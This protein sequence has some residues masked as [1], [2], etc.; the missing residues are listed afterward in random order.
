MAK[1]KRLTPAQPD[2]L[3]PAPDGLRPLGGMTP[4][5]IAQV[6]GEASARAALSEL[7]TAM[8]AARDEGRLIETLPLGAIDPAYLMRDRVVQDEDEMDALMTSIRVRGQQTP[9]EV[10]RLSDPKGDMAYGLISGWRRLTA[11]QR[12]HRV[13][14][15]GDT[16]RALVVTPDSTQAAYVAMVEE[17]EIRANL[18]HYERAQIVYRA[19]LHGIYPTQRAALQG[20]FGAV[21][22]SKRSKIG[23]FVP[24]VEAWDKVLQFPAAIP[25]KLGLDLARALNGDL[26]FANHVFSRLIDPPCKTAQEEQA[27]LLKALADGPRRSAS[28][29]PVMGEAAPRL[30]PESGSGKA[31]G[32]SAP[33]ATGLDAESVA[34][35]LGPPVKAAFDARAQRIEISGRGVDATLFQALEQWLRSRGGA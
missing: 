17:N 32:A 7:S 16:V 1:R 28:L 13:G 29:P 23:S 2:Y 34:R 26:G 19:C 5:P 8:E 22:R 20:L 3:A 21:S 4:A 25:E 6:A 30:E 18:S 31:P 35:R 12:L 24:L 15:G 10:V 11:L 9:I 33:R 14:D 27:R